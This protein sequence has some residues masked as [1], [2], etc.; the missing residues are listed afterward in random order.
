MRNTCY[1]HLLEVSKG[2]L[3]YTLDSAL[4]I[5]YSVYGKLLH[6]KI[7]GKS[8]GVQYHKKNMELYNAK[9]MNV[10]TL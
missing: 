3:H 4:Q 1:L 6:H 10:K 7:G 8:Y 2:K 9:Y 5:N